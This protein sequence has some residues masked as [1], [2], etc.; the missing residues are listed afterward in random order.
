VKSDRPNILYLHSHDT[1]RYVQP[2]GYA[3]ATPHIQ[4]LA[5]EGVLFRKAF[6]AA[7]TCSPSRASLLTGQHAHTS[8]MLGLAHRGFSLTTYQQHLLYTLRKEGYQSALIGEE[9]R[10]KITGRLAMT[11]STKSMAFTPRP[12]PPSLSACCARP[13]NPSSSR[14]VFFRRTVSF[15][16]PR[17]K[18]MPIIPDHRP[19]YLILPRPDAIWA[20]S[21]RALG[22]WI[23]A[24]GPSWRP[25]RK[26]D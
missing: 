18:E 14:S 20:P 13:R 15:S 11:A 17:P 8:G 7:P 4:A 24:L 1:G 25:Y 19:L 21:R 16:S 2:Y 23:G 12:L 6:C 5:E 10:P 9:H 26:A 22:I 3:I